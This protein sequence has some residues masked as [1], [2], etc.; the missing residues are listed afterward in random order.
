MELRHLRYF[1]A[2]AD[3]LHFS[4]AAAHLHVAQPALSQQIRQLEDE[5][6]LE[7]FRRT[8]RR[9]ELTDGGRV[10]LE[11]A[12]RTLAQSDRVISAAHRAAQGTA[13]Y[14]GVGFSSSAPYTT[15]P[16]ILRGFRA[17]FPDIVLNLHERSTEEQIDLL[18][19]G[20]IDIG[21]VRRPVE[22]APEALIIKTILREPLMV[23]LP[24]DHRLRFTPTVAVRA[25]ASEPFILF[26]R[27]AAPGL[28]DQIGALCRR[29]GFAPTVAQEAVQMQTIVSLVSAGLGV[30][31][32][33]ESIRNL[34]REHVLYRALSPGSARTQMAIAYDRRNESK[35]LESFV[36]IVI[37]MSSR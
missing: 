17:Q 27:H 24:H 21:F 36:R 33:P 37:A 20:T 28:Y 14:L 1:V 12:R 16:A 7:L 13:G 6:G 34:H 18:G 2:V 35:G 15:L 23:A 9:V 31:I 3:E 26:P 4:R 30:A 10:V 5:L 32:V 8:K 19:A 25:L 29:A 22:N 11:E